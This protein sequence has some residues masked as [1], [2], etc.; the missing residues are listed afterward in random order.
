MS[1][2]ALQK[3]PATPMWETS[4]HCYSLPR[5]CTSSQ[6]LRLDIVLTR[7]CYVMQEERNIHPPLL[8]KGFEEAHHLPVYCPWQRDHEDRQIS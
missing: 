3:P 6:Y 4:N 5:H 1:V 2:H 8:L 7:Y